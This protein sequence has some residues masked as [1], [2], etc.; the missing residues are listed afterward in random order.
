MRTFGTRKVDSLGRV[1][2]PIETRMALG[3]ED[4]DAVEVC[5]NDEK[6]IVLIKVE[7]E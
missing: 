1:V 3:I 6:Q 7:E 2:L 4:G 5:I